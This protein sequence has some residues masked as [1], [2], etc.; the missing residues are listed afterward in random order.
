MRHDADQHE[1]VLRRHPRHRTPGL[2]SAPRG[3]SGRIL[4]HLATTG[5]D[6]PARWVD[7]SIAETLSRKT[8]LPTLFVPATGRSLTAARPDH[9]T[10]G[11]G[12]MAASNLS[13]HRLWQRS[14]S[15]VKS[16][17]PALALRLTGGT[18]NMTVNLVPWPLSPGKIVTCLRSASLAQ[19]LFSSPGFCM[20]QGQIPLATLVRHPRLTMNSR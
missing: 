5:L 18:Q 20:Q 11:M 16:L 6:G 19:A 7:G 1:T 3:L 12:S 10:Q 9:Q 15:V 4:A 13:M 8:R 14:S 2:I 17:A